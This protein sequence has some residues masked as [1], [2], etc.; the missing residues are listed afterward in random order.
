MRENW[1]PIVSYP[2]IALSARSNIWNST[3]PSRRDFILGAGITGVGLLMT[4]SSGCKRIIDL[5]TP[6]ADTDVAASVNSPIVDTDQSKYYDNLKEISAPKK[7]DAFFGQDAQYQGRE[8]AYKDNGDGTVSDLNTGLMW[9]KSPDRNGEGVLNYTDKMYFDEAFASAASFNLAGYHDWRLPTIKELYSLMMFSGAE[10]N[11]DATSISGS[12]PFIDV[13]YFGVGYGD[14]GAGERLIDGQV[15][16]STVYVA[17]TY[18][19]TTD[20]ISF[21]IDPNGV[22]TM[23]GVNFIDGRIKGYPANTNKKYYVF[24]VRG[25]PDYGKND[26]VDTGDGT[27]TDKATGLMWGQADSGKGMNWEDALKWVQTKNAEY[28]LGYSDWRLPNAK[29]LQSIVDYTRSPSTTSSAAIDP[30]FNCTR[31]T[32][33]AGENDYPYYWTGTTFCSQTTTVGRS[34]VYVS[35]GR[36]MG[37]LNGKWV[38]VHGAGAQR[39]DPK[40]GSAASFPTGFGPQGDAIRINNY[41]RTVRYVG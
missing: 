25:N 39:S 2:G 3:R 32:N 24:F 41:V 31:I 19:K 5:T 30:M 13:A 8:P 22:K 21:E 7:A 35:F 12:I 26:F 4:L 9:P 37:F 34:A 33:E 28:Y 16:T 29:E 15:A 1:W 18:A 27:I 14:L 17:N 20:G 11:P 10:I 6:P 36:A 40:A 38:D 23:F